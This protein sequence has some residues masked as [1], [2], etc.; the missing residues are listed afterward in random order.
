MRKARSEPRVKVEVAS[1]AHVKVM[2]IVHSQQQLA[3]HEHN[4]CVLRSTRLRFFLLAPSLLCSSGRMAI[5]SSQFLKFTSPHSGT[6]TA[7]LSF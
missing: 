3:G 2:T 6:C 4:K 5:K 1:R 7:I